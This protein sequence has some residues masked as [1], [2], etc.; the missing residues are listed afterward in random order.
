MAVLQSRILFT[1]ANAVLTLSWNYCTLES[2][3]SAAMKHPIINV[4]QPLSQVTA[5][6]NSEGR[7]NSR[8]N[9]QFSGSPASVLY[10]LQNSSDQWPCSQESLFHSIAR[11]RQILQVSCCKWPCKLSGVCV[12]WFFILA[13]LGKYSISNVSN[14]STGIQKKC[15][16]YKIISHVPQV[17]VQFDHPCYK[18]NRTKTKQ[19]KCLPLSFQWPSWWSVSTEYQ[20]PTN[21]PKTRPLPSKARTVVLWSG[22]RSVWHL[23]FIPRM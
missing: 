14:W 5:N 1:F 21:E 3:Q 22:V 8:S 4:D 9:Q 2:W 10:M 13:C 6:K 16:K 7:M 19:L 23:K 12:Q 11:E 18:K 20:Y 17:I 15:I